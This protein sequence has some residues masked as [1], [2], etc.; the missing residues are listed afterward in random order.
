MSRLFGHVHDHVG[1][2]RAVSVTWCCCSVKS[3]C[4]RHA[5]QFHQPLEC[6]LAP[7]AAHIGPA[8]RGHQI[9]RLARQQILSARQHLHLALDGREC[10]DAIALDALNLLFGLRERFADR[11]HHRFDG[12]F[13][14]LQRRGRRPAAGA[15]AVRAPVAGTPRCCSSGCRG[16]ARRIPPA[17]ARAPAPA[18]VRARRP[19]SL[20]S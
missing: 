11:L 6:D 15:P 19:R 9:A 13:A 4:A 20:R 3:T 14:F 1:P 10:I 2:D 12:G 16:R 18:P 7:L 8:Q 5:G 17:V